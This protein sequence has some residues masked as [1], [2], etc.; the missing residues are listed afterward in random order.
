MDFRQRVD[1][2]VDTIT[3]NETRVARK[4]QVYIVMNKPEGYVTTRTDERG[5]ATVYDLLDK[6]EEWVFPV[7]RLDMDSSG[8]LIFTNDTRFGDKLTS[9]DSHVP[10]TYRVLLD[11]PLKPIHRKQIEEGFVLNG[12]QLLPVEMRSEKTSDSFWV[13]MTLHEGK[14]RQIRRMF[15][16]LGYEVK[17]LIRTRVGN[18]VLGGLER[19]KWKYLSKEEVELLSKS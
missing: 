14:N 10:K 7:G 9:P 11:I 5:R 18:F 16:S 15:E 2:D 17:E 6:V 1:P 13:E 4:P 12:E 8:L 3:V 19:G